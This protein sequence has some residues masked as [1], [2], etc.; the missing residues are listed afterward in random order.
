MLDVVDPNFLW[1]DFTFKTSRDQK[2]IDHFNDVVGRILK[3]NKINKNDLIV[4]VG[5]NDGTLLQCFSNNGYKNILGIDPASEIVDQ[6]NKKGIKTPT[7]L[8]SKK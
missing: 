6:A 4:D 2:L 8:L 3:I 5:S 1:S 7:G